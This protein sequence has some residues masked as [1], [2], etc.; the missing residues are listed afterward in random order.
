MNSAVPRSLLIYCTLPEG[1]IA[2]HAHYQACAAARAGID[3]TVLSPP[4]YLDDRRA[5]PYRVTWGL[6]RPSVSWRWRLAAKAYFAFAVAANHFVLAYYVVRRREKAVLF[7]AS[8][9]TLAFLW[10]W[11]HVALRFLGVRYA[12]NVL[13]PE[14]KKIGPSA[15][16]H[17]MSVKL[18]FAPIDIGIVHE[19]SAKDLPDIPQHVRLVRAPYGCYEIDLSGANGAQ[20]RAEVAPPG[21]RRCV[22]LSFGHIADRK[23]IDLFIR[24][25][26]ARPDAALIVAGPPASSRDRPALYY[27]ELATR[28]GVADRVKIDAGYVSMDDVKH[29]FDACD[30]ILLTY[31]SD[32]VSQSGVLLLTANCGKP[33]LASSGAGPLRSAVEAYGLGAGVNPDSVSE[34]ERGIAAIAAMP[35]DAS[36]WKRFREHASWDVNIAALCSALSQIESER[37][38]GGCAQVEI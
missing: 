29:Y 7:A 4:D 24:A 6:L 13:D 15:A 18:S 22:F 31:R 27:Q 9:E 35:P 12:A 28:L 26:P 11:P 2:E 19:D 3:V 32:F 30:A 1:G 23:N 34:L 17:R 36:A 33:V 20:I 8:S 25:M 38:G 5:K 14:R 37:W 21:A 16:L 10:I